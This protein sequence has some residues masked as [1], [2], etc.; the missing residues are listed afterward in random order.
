[1][2]IF[3]SML[4]FLLM[5][6][7]LSMPMFHPLLHVLKQTPCLKLCR[8][9]IAYRSVFITH[10]KVFSRYSVFM[11]FTRFSWCE[12][13]RKRG[14]GNLR[15]DRFTVPFQAATARIEHHLL[16]SSCRPHHPVLNWQLSSNATSCNK[17]KGTNLD[18]A[19]FTEPRWSPLRAEHMGTTNH[20]LPFHDIKAKSGRLNT[21]SLGL[22]GGKAQR[23]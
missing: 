2:S 10:R 19:V 11:T 14:G 20:N 23:T 6:I 9:L 8:A 7:S 22:N 5:L 3:S 18:A 21:C 15:D 1:M 17:R 4:T 12:I 13:R 16:E